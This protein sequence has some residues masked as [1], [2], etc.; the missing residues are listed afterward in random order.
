MTFEILGDLGP[1]LRGSVWQ[2]VGELF[3]G[4]PVRDLPGNPQSGPQPL[5]DHTGPPTAPVRPPRPPWCSRCGGLFSPVRRF[6]DSVPQDD[7]MRF[8]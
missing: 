7:R 3:D 5:V 8:D 1:P 6:R 2:Q 4:T